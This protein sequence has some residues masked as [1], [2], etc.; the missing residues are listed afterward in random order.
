[1]CQIR[2]SKSKCNEMEHVLVEERLKTLGLFSLEKQQFS[3]NMTEVCR[4]MHEIQK[5]EK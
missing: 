5:V 2:K 3:D 1:M 4:I